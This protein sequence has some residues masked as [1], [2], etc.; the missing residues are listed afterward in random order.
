M[1]TRI[2]MN[3]KMKWFTPSVN[4]AAQN[5]KLAEEQASVGRY[6]KNTWGGGKE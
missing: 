3:E 6:V 2:N 1:T 4:K 5:P